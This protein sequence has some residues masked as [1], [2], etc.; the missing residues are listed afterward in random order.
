MTQFAGPSVRLLAAFRLPW[1]GG[2]VASYS[3]SAACR[4]IGDNLLPGPPRAVPEAV[5]L[6]T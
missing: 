4:W 5:A 6:G 1:R 3:P 2:L